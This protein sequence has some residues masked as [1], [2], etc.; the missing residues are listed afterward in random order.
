M[1]D[2]VGQQSISGRRWGGW[3]EGLCRQLYEFKTLSELSAA[4]GADPRKS[5][6]DYL[7]GF[8]LMAETRGCQRGP[9]GRQRPGEG[10]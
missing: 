4:S 6:S 2:K 5:S 8:I 10:L 9:R 1:R 7:H 3:G